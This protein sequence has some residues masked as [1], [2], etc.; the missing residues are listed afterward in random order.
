MC[1]KVS[2]MSHSD[3]DCEGSNRLGNECSNR[4]YAALPGAVRNSRGGTAVSRQFLDSK[5]SI[6][7]RKLRDSLGTTNEIFIPHLKLRDRLKSGILQGS[8]IKYRLKIK[9]VI[10]SN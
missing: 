7:V 1:I 2:R 4:P 9:S 10:S 6:S 3:H 5:A 8:R